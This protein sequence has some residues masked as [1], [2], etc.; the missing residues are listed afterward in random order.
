MKMSTPIIPTKNEHSNLTI[1]LEPIYGIVLAWVILQEHKVLTLQFYI[2]AAIIVAAVFSY[3][4]ILRLFEK[5]K[6]E[7][8]KA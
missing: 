8:D 1:N 4:Y 6:I 2:G 3:P 7:S 5:E